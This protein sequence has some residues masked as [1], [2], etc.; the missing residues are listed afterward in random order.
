MPP[1]IRSLGRNV[2][3]LAA[4]RQVQVRSPS[5]SSAAAP[6]TAAARRLRRRANARR[7]RS[8]S[9]S[10]ATAAACPLQATVPAAERHARRARRARARFERIDRLRNG[11]RVFLCDRAGEPAGS[12]IVYGSGDCGLARRSRRRAPTRQPAA[13]AGC[14]P[15]PA[16]KRRGR[17]LAR[18]RW[19]SSSSSSRIGWA[20]WLLRGS[21]PML[22]GELALPGLSAP[23]QVERDA[24]GVASI[25]AAN[26]VDA[27]RALGFVHGQERFFEMDLL[28][29]S[30]AGE[31]SELF[32]AIAVDKDKSV[33]V[34]RLRAR[35]EASLAAVAGTRMPQLAAYG[36]GVNQGLAS[37]R[38][39]PWP[40]LLL[41]VQPRPWQPA[42]TALAGYAMFFDLQDDSNSARTG[43]VEDPPVPP[44]RPLPAGCRRRHRVGRA[45]ARPRA[46]QRTPARPR[47]TRPAPAADAR[48]QGD[49]W[50]RGRASRARQQQLRRRRRAHRRRPRDPGQRHAPDPARAEHLVPR[51]PAVRRPAT[52]PA[53]A[54]TCP[55]SRCR[56]FPAVVVGSNGHVAWASPIPT[57]TGSTS[58]ACAGRTHRASA[59]AP[60]SATCHCRCT[61]NAST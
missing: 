36:E 32:G 41:R 10:T 31:L 54:S 11:T 7:S 33:R 49:R 17:W 48:P 43:L 26:A 3:Y 20:W 27:A 1:Q 25:H 58:T 42:D 38:S 55:A 16:M 40:Y 34:H 13:P 15:L 2:T 28:R 61:K 6:G 37:L 45:A 56:E 9:A 30:A 50:Q 24:N 22:E 44:A 46:R 51:A 5:A 21:L 52:R 4:G 47:R 59:I 35:T 12:A 29:R 8:P 19:R 57:G 53:A 60:A 18:G 39:K 23:V 14:A